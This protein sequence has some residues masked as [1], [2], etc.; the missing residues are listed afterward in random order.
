MLPST[1]LAKISKAYLVLPVEYVGGVAITPMMRYWEAVVTGEREFLEAWL[2]CPD[3]V[4]CWRRS[5]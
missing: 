1:S 4:L 2:V 5:Y 3:S